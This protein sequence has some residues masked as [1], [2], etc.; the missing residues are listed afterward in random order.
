[1]LNFYYKSVKTPVMKFTNDSLKFR[2]KA[3]RQP[4]YYEYNQA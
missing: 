1:M 4:C 2:P 3:G